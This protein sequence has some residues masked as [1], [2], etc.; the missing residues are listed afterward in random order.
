[1]RGLEVLERVVEF[2][3]AIEVVLMRAL[4]D[5][6]SGGAPSRKVLL[7]LSQQRVSDRNVTQ[8]R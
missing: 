4:H 8:P 6:I 3:P 5:G 7:R 1:M 2:D